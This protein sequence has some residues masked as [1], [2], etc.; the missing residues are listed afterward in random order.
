M[1]GGQLHSPI[2]Y[3]C[4]LIAIITE[5]VVQENENRFSAGNF[6]PYMLLGDLC[7]RNLKTKA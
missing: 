5:M 4:N 3:E 6:T 2:F 7:N 1:N